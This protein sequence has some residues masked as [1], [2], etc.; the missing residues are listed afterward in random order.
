ML[1]TANIIMI[2]GLLCSAAIIA[3]SLPLNRKGIIACTIAINLLNMLIFSLSGNFA[4]TIIVAITLLYAVIAIFDNRYPVL[5]SNSV[6]ATVLI[7]YLVA[8]VLTTDNFISAQLLTLVG[9]MTG[10][11]AMMDIRPVSVKI[12]QIVGN[13]CFTSFSVVIGSYGQLPGQIFAFYVLIASLVWIIRK[14]IKNNNVNNMDTTVYVVAT[15]E[16]VAA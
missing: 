4:S 10:I 2:A 16:L 9:C 1:T 8:Y 3:I 6:I 15:K 11:I 14:N 13:V 7:A 5:K 12:I